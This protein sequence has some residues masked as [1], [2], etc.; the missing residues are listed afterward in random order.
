MVNFLIKPYILTL[1]GIGILGFQPFGF[2]SLSEMT[3][4]MQ[5]SIPVNLM[6]VMAQAF[7]LAGNYLCTADCKIFM[8]LL[9]LMCFCLVIGDN[10]IWGMV[11]LIVPCALYITFLHKTDARRQQA[12]IK[13]GNLGGKVTDDG[14]VL[15]ERPV[16]HE[17]SKI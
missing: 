12:E 15:S 4:P 17:M 6:M 1:L 3:F 16:L 8:F 11:G 9:F 13:Y 5:D 14:H 10:G 2:Q 7:G